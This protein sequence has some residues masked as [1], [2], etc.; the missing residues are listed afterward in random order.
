MYSSMPADWLCC[1]YL[2]KSREDEER[3]KFG[4]G[5]TLARHEKIVHRM[6]E[7]NG[8]EI[9]E[10]YRE[11]VSGETIAGRPEMI[12]LLSDI[13]SGKWD[14]VYVV[15]ASR[16]G[17]G[18]G[19]DQEKIVNAFRYTETFLI[20]EYKMYDPSSQSDMRQLKS[21]LRSS[22]D[23]LESI[24]ARLTRGKYESA[25][26]GRWQATG[27]TPYGWKAVRIDGDWQ[28]RPDEHHDNLLRIYDLLDQGVGISAIADLY[29]KE[30]VPTA[31][32]GYHWTAAAVRAIVLN[33]AN[34]GY[35]RYA[36][37]VTKKVF[38]PETFQVKKVRVKNTNPIV[39]KGLHYGIGCI[40]EERFDRITRNLIAKA[41][42][43]WGLET[44]NPLAG[45]LICGKCGYTL[46]YHTCSGVPRFDHK[47]RK[48]M[49]RPC[50]GCKSVKVSTLME[51]VVEA[52]KKT[53]ADIEI[54]ISDNTTMQKYEQH[55]ASLKES[56]DRCERSKER[57]LEAY[58]AGVYGVEDL[59]KRKEAIEAEMIAIQDE[60][61]KSKPPSYSESTI[62][63]LHE[64]ID[65][66]LDDEIP[67]SRKNDFLKSVIKK[68]DYYNDG[69]RY[70]TESNIKLEIHLR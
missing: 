40:D 2:R 45:I 38:D 49:T 52:L 7:D 4:K 46:E 10:I 47:R 30:H 21:E 58:E 27:R 22:E 6:A 24:S 57:I 64:C 55:V 43:R 16:L 28:L 36:T 63:S 15:E 26:E 34:C 68:I 69:R 18:G 31:R 17:R 11:I 9:A 3:E 56:L 48:G 25:R 39:V 12:R 50:D 23:E 35:I 42:T 1:A 29:N 44:R 67:A 61:K 59:R 5:E 14:A 60:L 54:E 41:R 20:S 51:A 37:H 8:H 53:I 66:I 33:P 19:S 32:G 70:T 62:V 65:A 13:A